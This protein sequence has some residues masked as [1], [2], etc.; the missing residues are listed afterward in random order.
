[1]IVRRRSDG[2]LDQCEQIAR[3]V[4]DLD[5]YPPHLPSEL[6]RFI[7]SPDAIAAWVAENRDRL[8][9]HV[10]LH[11]TSSP[12]VMALASAAT[13]QQPE[14]LGLVARLFVSPAARRN[15]VARSLLLV[16]TAEAEARGLRPILDVGTHFDAAISL[17]ER[18]GWV[19]AGIVTVRFRD[20]ALKEF[21]YLSPVPV[22]A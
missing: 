19:R 7:D 1:V 18:C 13:G 21:V 6:R 10:A 9:G 15:G 4:H 8:L 16:A 12:E 11:P 20:M 2:D 3:L 17:Y 22:S 14:G 5:G